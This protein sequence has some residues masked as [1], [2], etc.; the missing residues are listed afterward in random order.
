MCGVRGT[1]GLVVRAFGRRMKA[2]VDGPLP[3]GHAKTRPYAVW[4]FSSGLARAR[5]G[6]GGEVGVGGAVLGADYFG[7]FLF[8]VRSYGLGATRVP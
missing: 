6:V 3:W 5:D 7:F 2:D 4:A 8:G 1:V